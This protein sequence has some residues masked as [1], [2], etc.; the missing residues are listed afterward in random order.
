MVYVPLGSPPPDHFGGQRRAFDEQFATSI[1]ALDARTGRVRWSFQTVHHDLWDYDL[2]SP[3]LTDVRVGD[4]IVPALLQPTKRGQLFLLDRRTGKPLSRVV[5]QR[6]P[7]GGTVPGERLAGTQPYSVGLPALS[8]P[9]LTERDMWGVTALDQLWCRITFRQ[10]RFE[11]EFTPPGL[12]PFLIYP[13]YMGGSNWG[14]VS[15]D[16]RR[17]V[18]IVNTLRLATRAHLI[19]D[20]ER[21]ERGIVPLDWSR[22]GQPGT[23]HPSMSA[24][25]GTPVGVQ[26]TP[27][28]SPLNIPCQQPPYGTISAVNLRTRKLIWT[29]PLGTARESGPMGIRSGL[30]LPIGTPMQGGALTTASGLTFIGATQDAYFRALETA[31]GRQLWEAKLPAGGHASPATFMTASGRQLVVIAAG[32]SMPLRSRI[33]DYIIAYGLPR[34]REG[35][36]SEQ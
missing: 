19:P 7:T 25:G 20:A 9:A 22:L 32:G 15:I 35:T 30:P 21:R 31:S 6:V 2:A 23:G 26:L 4:A 17:G 28:L 24:Q 5:E 13:G 12:K 34:G 10:T 16:S 11:G 36:G 3:S 33:G 1:V 27:F 18:A 14:G 29:K 8:G